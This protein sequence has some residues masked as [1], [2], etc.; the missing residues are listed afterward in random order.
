MAGTGVVIPK[1]LI[2]FGNCVLD[3]SAFELRRGRRVVKLE[4][5]PLQV[6]L[7]LI[8]EQGQVVTREEIADQIWGK[9]VF[10]DVDNGINT[11]IRKIRQVLN[12]DPQTPQFVETIPGRGYRFI[13][14][15]E[16]TK[17]QSRPTESVPEKAPSPAIAATINP[18]SAVSPATPASRRGF[19]W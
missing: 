16:T 14:P 7:I 12:D 5:I 11:A 10:L 17:T 13:A 9:D 15:L 1:N 18:G 3:A 2:R 19:P 8:E 4:R 6:L